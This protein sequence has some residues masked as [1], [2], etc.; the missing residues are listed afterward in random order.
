MLVGNTGTPYNSCGKLKITG[1]NPGF[2]CTN[3]NE[4][5]V[6]ECLKAGGPKPEDSIA[7]GKILASSYFPSFETAMSIQNVHLKV[8]I[9]IFQVQ[10]METF[11]TIW[12]GALETSTQSWK[13]FRLML[14]V[15][16][17][18]RVRTVSEELNV[19]KP[20]TLIKYR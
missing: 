16:P 4:V 17:D 8:T 2:S 14:N 6:Y 10:K 3:N 1:G 18:C 7:I 13:K 9:F 20:K 5:L 19:K 11:V 15:I 12:M